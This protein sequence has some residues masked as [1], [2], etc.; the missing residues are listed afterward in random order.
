MAVALVDTPTL[1]DARRAGEALVAAG[2]GQVWLFGSLARG[3][4]R[5]YSDIDLVAVLDDLDYRDRWRIEAELRKAASAAAGRPVD[6]VVTDRPEWE[7]QR[8]QV[9]ASFTVAIGEDLTLLADRPPMKRVNWD[10]EQSMATSNEQ[11][12]AQRIEDMVGQLAKILGLRWPSRDELQAAD[13]D[14]REW[15]AGAR[16]IGLC[17][18][19][20]LAVEGSLKAVGTLTGVQ[21]K[22]LHQHDVQTIADALPPDERDTMLALMAA[23]PGLVK[24]PGYITM[25]RTK[26]TYTSPTGG[27]TAQE[28]ATPRFAAAMVGIAVEVADAAVNW[29]ARLGIRPPSLAYFATA[30]EQIRAHIANTDLGTGQPLETTAAHAKQDG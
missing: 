25:W 24:I 23:A 29:A 5:T 21:A 27:M 28:I 6:V 9:S 15:L 16:M 18:A 8:Q 12:A 1:R 11:L 17:E 22:V 14:E 10:K 2:V 26:G 7:V 3:E 19:A 20:H 13:P 30:V 4:E